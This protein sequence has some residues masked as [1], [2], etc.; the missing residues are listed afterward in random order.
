GG[1]SPA[2]LVQA[3]GEFRASRGLSS[4]EDL[5]TWL[6]GN[7]VDIE[8]LSRRLDESVRV[9]RIFDSLSDESE[10]RMLDLLVLD[11]RNA[12]S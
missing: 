11:V 3:V 2:M 9:S 12:A 8:T 6:S 5:S 7:G 1:N 4:A 10:K